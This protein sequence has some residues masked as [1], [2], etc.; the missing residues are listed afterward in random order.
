[1]KLRLVVASGVHEGKAIPITT[2]QFV[3]GRDPQCQLRPASPAI[4]KRHCAVLVRGG[5][6]FVRDFGST[7]GTFVNDQLVQGEVE[8]HDGDRLKIGPLDFTVGLELTRA[9]APKPAAQPVAAAAAP[10]AAPAGADDEAVDV[11]A[12]VAPSD[13]PASDKIA[14]LLLD[15]DGPA[16]SQA[17]TQTLDNSPVPDG[18]TVMEIP[19]AD[20]PGAPGQK[21][22]PKSVIGTGNTSQAAADILSKYYRRPRS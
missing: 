16:A 6:V 3:V 5:K 7:N 18:S 15:D 17:T 9:P 22:K 21:A 8:V 19:A 2:P 12:K 10:P 13:G 14:E 11:T 4:S 20:K 1:M